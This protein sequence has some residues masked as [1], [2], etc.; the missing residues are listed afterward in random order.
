MT[1]IKDDLQFKDYYAT[2]R[3]SAIGQ[4]I[5][6]SCN[7]ILTHHDDKIVLKG[8]LENL[9]LAYNL[10]FGDKDVD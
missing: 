10:L 2:E 3:W 1:I 4:E 9:M 7:Q 6:N 5:Q 8:Q